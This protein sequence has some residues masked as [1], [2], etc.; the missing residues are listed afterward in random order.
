MLKVKRIY[1]CGDEP[2][3]ERIN[4]FIADKEVV[5]IKYQSGVVYDKFGNGIPNRVRS[6]DRALIVYKEKENA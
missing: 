6:F 3:D 2:F 1:A 4:E 5:D